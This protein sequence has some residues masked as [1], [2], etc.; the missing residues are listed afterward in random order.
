[1]MRSR[2]PVIYV[3]VLY[4]DPQKPPIVLR[5]EDYAQ[6]PIDSVVDSRA[7]LLS[8]QEAEVHLVAQRARMN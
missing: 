7:H 6:L 4:D 8:P 3:M 5:V 1:M 2:V